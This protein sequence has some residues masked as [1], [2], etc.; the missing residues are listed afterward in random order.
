MLGSRATKAPKDL[1][2]HFRWHGDAFT[3]GQIID[4]I[5]PRTGHH[6]N[7]ASDPFIRLLPCIK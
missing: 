7:A 5:T 2:S 4:T 1:E 6:K 3:D